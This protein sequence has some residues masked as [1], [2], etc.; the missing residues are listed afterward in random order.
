ME[1]LN[2]DCR[3]VHLQRSNKWDAP[4]DVLRAGKRVQ[5]LSYWERTSRTY[6]KQDDDYWENRIKERQTKR[7]RISTELIE[8]VD[9][10][11]EFDISSL[12]ANEIK[13]HLNDMGI[14]TRLRC[15]KKLGVLLINSLKDK[16]NQPPNV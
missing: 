13:K 11:T 7:H 10:N 4:T 2:D 3:R 16:E 5:Y 8:T 15:V 9:D 14:K 1:K 12:T 6:T